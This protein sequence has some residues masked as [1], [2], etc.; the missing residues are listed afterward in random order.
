[1][2]HRGKKYRQS[3][4]ET[5]KKTGRPADRQAGRPRERR[6][7]GQTDGWKKRRTDGWTDGWTDNSLPGDFG[8]QFP[9]LSGDFSPSRPPLT[10]LG[11]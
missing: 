10:T 8:I 5:D 6:V 7:D 3:D 11:C 1:M 4:S 2:E 9:I